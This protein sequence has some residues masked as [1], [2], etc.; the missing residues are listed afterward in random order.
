M[1]TATRYWLCG[2]E[3]GTW[4]SRSV[5]SQPLVCRFQNW[6]QEAR[7]TAFILFL[8]RSDK[9]ELGSDS[10]SLFDCSCQKPLSLAD[11]A[12]HVTCLW[13]SVVTARPMMLGPAEAAG[14]IPLFESS[15]KRKGCNPAFFMHLARQ[16]AAPS[17]SLVRRPDA[18]D[19]VLLSPSLRPT[20]MV[21][22]LASASLQGGCISI[23]L[24]FDGESLGQRAKG[25][26]VV[27][28]AAQSFLLSFA[29][30]ALRHLPLF[31]IRI[32]FFSA[33]KVGRTTRGTHTPPCMVLAGKASELRKKRFFFFFFALCLVEQ[34]LQGVIAPKTLAAPSQLSH[35]RHRLRCHNRCRTTSPRCPLPVTVGRSDAQHRTHASWRMCFMLASASFSDATASR[36]QGIP[37]VSCLVS[38]RFVCF[39]CAGARQGK[40]RLSCL[41]VRPP[42]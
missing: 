18:E 24:R 15:G 32:C 25:Y 36:H 30:E 33:K 38:V 17:S 35:A 39:R 11:L 27:L 26:V 14:V 13:A 8:T 10:R 16:I 1:R 2:G 34:K 37:F 20:T 19:V 6:R 9:V 22:A 5:L 42:S 41:L 40:Q 23:L 28:L 7:K 4:R 21:F 12:Y 3:S 29:A 31:C